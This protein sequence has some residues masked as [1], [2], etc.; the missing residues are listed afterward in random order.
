MK[1]ERRSAGDRWPPYMVEVNSL[2]ELVNLL[3]EHLPV[4]ARLV[5]SED[6]IIRRDEDGDLVL[7][8]YDDWCE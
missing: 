2:E 7:E 6:Y 1:V 3:V 8:D 5:S 4:S